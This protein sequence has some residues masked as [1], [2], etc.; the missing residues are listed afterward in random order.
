MV[1]TS[2]YESNDDKGVDLRK[3]N[4]GNEAR[5]GSIPPRWSLKG[6]KMRI[7]D[8]YIRVSFKKKHEAEKIKFMELDVS[9][10]VLHLDLEAL[11]V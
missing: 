6:E 4:Q 7:I 9:T 1:K 2:D 8:M 3:F 10:E 5:T 11:Q